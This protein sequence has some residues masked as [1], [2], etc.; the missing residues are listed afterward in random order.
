MAP[1]VAWAGAVMV[2]EGGAGAGTGTEEVAVAEAWPAALMAMH[3]R[4]SVPDPSI[5]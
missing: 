5:R 2:A 4:V 3:S 1:A